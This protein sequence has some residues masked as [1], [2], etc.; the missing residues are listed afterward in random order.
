MAALKASGIGT[1][2][3]YPIPL[4]LQPA[5]ARCGGRAGDLPVVEA[6]AQR[7][8]SL[9]IYPELRDEQVRAVARVLRESLA[10]LS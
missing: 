3:H 4:H 6:A 9:P 5:F 7:I 10:G 2:I 1:L 8:F